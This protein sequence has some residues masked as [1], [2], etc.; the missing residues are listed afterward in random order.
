MI[1]NKNNKNGDFKKNR[2]NKTA[3]AI[4][5]LFIQFCNTIC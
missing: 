4:I 1:Q 2:Y 5:W 3:A